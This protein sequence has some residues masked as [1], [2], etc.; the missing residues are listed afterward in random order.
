MRRHITQDL[1]RFTHATQRALECSWGFAFK[2]VI[3]CV[4]TDLTYFIQGPWLRDDAYALAGHFW[5][6]HKAY[7][8]SLD[9]GRSITMF[10]AAKAIYTA[11]DQDVGFGLDVL[12]VQGLG[13][14]VFAEAFDFYRASHTAQL[15][16]RSRVLILQGTPRYRENLK[17][18]VWSTA[19]KCGLHS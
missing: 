9:R 16:P 13:E 1:N 18:P 4:D 3:A 17:I 19:F 10:K 14:S 15:T 5:G 11:C 7:E 6:L 12:K 8:E 2:Q